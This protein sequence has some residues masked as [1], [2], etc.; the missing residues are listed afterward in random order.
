MKSRGELGTALESCA[1]W[2]GWWVYLKEMLQAFPLSLL[3]LPRFYF[4]ALLFTLHRSPSSERLE[5]VNSLC[6]T[7]SGL[8]RDVTRLGEIYIQYMY[9][10][11]IV[12]DWN[13]LQKCLATT[14]S[15]FQS[16]VEEKNIDLHLRLQRLTTRIFDY[17]P[18]NGQ[19]R[20]RVSKYKSSVKRATVNYFSI[21]FLEFCNLKWLFIAECNQSRLQIRVPYAW[22]S[23]GFYVVGNAAVLK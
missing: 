6:K 8:L 14:Y 10:T 13:I 12:F 20:K 18:K 1:V 5:Q 2:V 17:Q 4:I 9:S 19:K 21:V 7:S 16:A 15:T 23:I 3:P 11:D 22:I